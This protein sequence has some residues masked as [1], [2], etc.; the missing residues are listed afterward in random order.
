MLPLCPKTGYKFHT[1]QVPTKASFVSPATLV[2][3]IHARQP[4]A[5]AGQLASAQSAG[6]PVWQDFLDY[7][8]VA[9][10][11]Q[12]TQAQP[13]SRSLPQS[14]RDTPTAGGQTGTQHKHGEAA[15]HMADRAAAPTGTPGTSPIEASPWLHLHLVT[16]AW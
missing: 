5:C 2:E 8:A 6:N 16:H 1:T 7:G 15:G 14:P 4:I 3:I 13:E 9:R 12:A 10:E 11:L